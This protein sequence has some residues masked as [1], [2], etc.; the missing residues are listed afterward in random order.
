M[1]SDRTMLYQPLELYEEGE[2]RDNG[3]SSHNT[4]TVD[5]QISPPSSKKLKVQ[6]GLGLVILFGI[7]LGLA[8]F[9]HHQSLPE[10]LS[11][12]PTHAEETTPSFNWILEARH[13]IKNFVPHERNCT[14][15]FDM[16]DAG[17]TILTLF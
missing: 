8:T 11:A 15:D 7:L 13:T 14:G 12:P 2:S 10:D 17:T 4:D 3:A 6:V 16:N 5:V 1:T 9:R